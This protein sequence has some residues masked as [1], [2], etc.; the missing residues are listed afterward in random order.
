MD[1][2]KRVRFDHFLAKYVLPYARARLEEKG[3]TLENVSKDEVVCTVDVFVSENQYKQTM[4]TIDNNDLSLIF[5]LHYRDTVVGTKNAYD[6]LYDSMDIFTNILN[7]S[8]VPVLLEFSMTIEFA[9]RAS[10]KMYGEILNMS[11]ICNEFEVIYTDRMDRTVKMTIPV[12]IDDDTILS[13]DPVV[14]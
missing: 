2:F 13:L 9:Y 1:D 14:G 8:K 5:K 3:Y 4:D 11:V 7:A 6:E 10:I 12:V